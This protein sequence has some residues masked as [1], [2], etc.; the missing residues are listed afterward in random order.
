MSR[1][2]PL[3][4]GGLAAAGALAA[5]LP[6]AEAQPSHVSNVCFHFGHVEN[7]KLADPRTLYLRADGGRIFRIGFSN[8]CST[9][10]TYGLIL[11][12]VNNGGEICSAIELDIAVRTTG[13]RCVPTSFARLT[14]EEAAAIPA[15]YRP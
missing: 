10:D 11:H 9:G 7:S 1:L 4:L 14:P 3:A 12:P 2:I 6:T 5:T 8:D 15:K 13:E